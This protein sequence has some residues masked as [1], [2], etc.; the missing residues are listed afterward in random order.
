MKSH[1]GKRLGSGRKPT[2][3]KSESKSIS[4]LKEQW[5]KVDKLRGVTSRGK[6]IG[7]LVDRG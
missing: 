6:W 5:D 3:R 4:L 7:Y 2:G 1:G